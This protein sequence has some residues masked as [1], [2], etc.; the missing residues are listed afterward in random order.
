MTPDGVRG[1][2]SD[3]ERARVVEGLGSGRSRLFQAIAS[4]PL[5]AALD[6]LFTAERSRFDE[7][8]DTVKTATA[9]PC[10]VATWLFGSV[11]R[12][13][14]T[15]DSDLDI[16][17]VID[18]DP[19]QVDA[20]ADGVRDALWEHEKRSGFT[21]SVVAMSLADVA[22]LSLGTKEQTPL[23]HNLLTEALVLKGI[24]PA[25]AAGRASSHHAARS[26]H[27]RRKPFRG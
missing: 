17:V 9:D 19:G 14:D 8:V 12:G 7:I 26:S 3:L 18:A 21:A 10:I 22:R 27:R 6:A 4:H 24:A 11:A 15:V 1:V 2:L 25:A 20:I 16:A 13:E 5:V 23:W